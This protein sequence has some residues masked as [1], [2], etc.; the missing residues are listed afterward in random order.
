MFYTLTFAVLLP[1][2]CF[3]TGDQ[4]QRYCASDFFLQ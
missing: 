3:S 4:L 2:Y 1:K